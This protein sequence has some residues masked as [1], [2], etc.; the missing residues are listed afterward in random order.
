MLQAVP[1]KCVLGSILT[2][3]HDLPQACISIF[4]RSFCKPRSHG[5]GAPKFWQAIV[6][7]DALCADRAAEACGLMGKPVALANG[8][9]D[10]PHRG[11]ARREPARPSTALRKSRPCYFGAMPCGDPAFSAMTIARVERQPR[12]TRLSKRERWPFRRSQSHGAGGPG[13]GSQLQRD[14]PDR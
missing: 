8:R 1:Q 6:L 14:Q 9:L 2:V 5:N 12:S 10:R 4:G 3:L 7:R 11:E 13:Q